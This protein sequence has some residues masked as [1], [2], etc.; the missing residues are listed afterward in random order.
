M[1]K[2]ILDEK[3]KSGVLIY[4][5]L[6]LGICTAAYVGVR[7]LTKTSKEQQYE[8]KMELIINAGKKYAEQIQDRLSSRCFEITVSDLVKLDLVLIMSVEP[9]KSGQKFMESVVYKLDALNIEIKEKNYKT[10]ISIDGGIN[11]ETIEF[12]RD[13]VDIVTS[14]SYLHEGDI[15]VSIDILRGK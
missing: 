10:L 12:V 9:G 15:D 3:R 1:A 5:I 6:F 4:V 8:E 7:S 13:K 14:A 11:S 2:T